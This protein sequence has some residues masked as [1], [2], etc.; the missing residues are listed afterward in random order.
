[1][2][3][4]TSK[5]IENLPYEDEMERYLKKKEIQNDILKKIIRKINSDEKKSN[6]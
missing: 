4:K 1:M 6:K 2:K 5:E 3:E